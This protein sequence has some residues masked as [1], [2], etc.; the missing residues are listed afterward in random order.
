ML[1]HRHIAKLFTLL[2]AALLLLALPRYAQAQRVRYVQY[3]STHALAVPENPAYRFQWTMTWGNQ[4]LPI[5]IQSTTNVTENIRWDRR[6]THYDIT[7]YPILDSVGCLGEPVYLRVYTVDYLSLHAFNDVFFTQVNQAV[8]GDVSDNDFD[9]LGLILIYNPTLVS[10]PS[11]GTV[12]MDVMGEFTYT[13]DPG[14]TGI[15]YF[16]YEVRTDAD[17]SMFGTAQVTIVVRDDD[18]IAE[19]YVEKTGPEKALYGERIQ[20]S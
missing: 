17:P 1:R 7:V 18:E 13:P 4:N 20:Y 8:T 19:L 12:S 2:T 5:P 10:G 9:E 16:V 15:D 3:N 6:N 14:F 11:N